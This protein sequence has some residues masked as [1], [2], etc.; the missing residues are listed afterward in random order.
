M[1]DRAYNQKINTKTDYQNIDDKI[2]KKFAFYSTQYNY[3]SELEG[4]D[5]MTRK[6]ID[7]S[8]FEAIQANL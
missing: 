5:M 3:V 2:D 7:F 4:M 6:D 8:D 1:F